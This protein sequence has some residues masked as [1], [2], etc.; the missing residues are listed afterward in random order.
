MTTPPRHPMPATLADER[1]ML[2]GWLDHH[3]DTLALKCAGLTD[4]QLRAR[5]VAPSGLSLLG[6]VR[7]LTECERGWFRVTMAGEA[8][9]PF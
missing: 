9:D 1:T 3:R 2:E 7:H 4:A 5:V 6:L 8:A